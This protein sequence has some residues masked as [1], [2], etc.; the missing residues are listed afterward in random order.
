MEVIT[1]PVI[2]EA[3]LAVTSEEVKGKEIVEDINE[4]GLGCVVHLCGCD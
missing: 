1:A 3:V 2:E 4:K